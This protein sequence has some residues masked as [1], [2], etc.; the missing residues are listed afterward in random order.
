MSSGLNRAVDAI[1]DAVEFI[2]GPHGL[3]GFLGVG[4]EVATDVHR[5]ALNLVQG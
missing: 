3:P 1:D 4:L 5:F 2:A